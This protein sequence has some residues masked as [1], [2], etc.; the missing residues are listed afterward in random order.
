MKKL[1]SILAFFT[2]LA[3]LAAMAHGTYRFLT[4]TCHKYLRLH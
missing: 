4:A 1:F 2:T 3:G